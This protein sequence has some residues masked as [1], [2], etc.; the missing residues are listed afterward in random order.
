[1]VPSVHP[2]M[3]TFIGTDHN[4]LWELHDEAT[5]GRWARTETNPR[6]ATPDGLPSLRSSSTTLPSGPPSGNMTFR[7]KF[8]QFNPWC[9]PS[10]PCVCTWLVESVFPS[11]FM[12]IFSTALIV[13]HL[14]INIHQHSWKSFEINPT[15]MLDVVLISFYASID[16]PKLLFKRHQHTTK[17]FSCVPLMA[18]SAYAGMRLD[19]QWRVV[20]ASDSSEADGTR[21]R[22]GVNVRS[23]PCMEGQ[24]RYNGWSRWWLTK[25]RRMKSA[26]QGGRERER[27]D[28]TVHASGPL[29]EGYTS[30]SRMMRFPGFSL[31]NGGWFR[32]LGLKTS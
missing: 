12:C 17:I 4:C 8:R 5:C 13:F 30:R 7:D 22:V 28:L 19:C 2:E 10:N 25:S 3:V 23:P 1:M 29:D 24:R 15:T 6:S 32:V 9:G 11:P 31:K 27:E 14:H 20:R 26:S 21:G 16:D 18:V